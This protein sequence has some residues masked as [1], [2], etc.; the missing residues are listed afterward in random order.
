M[1]DDVPESGLLSPGEYIDWSSCPEVERSPGKVS[2]VPILKRTRVQAD[3]IWIN[4]AEGLSAEEV[5]DLFDLDTRQVQ[6]VIEY[7]NCH[8]PHRR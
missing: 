1:A 6:A 3:G 4:H 5:A 8:P 2:G 7:T